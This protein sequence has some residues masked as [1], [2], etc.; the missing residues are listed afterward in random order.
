MNDLDLRTALHRD[1][2]LVGEPSPDLLEQLGQRRRRERRQRFGVGGAVLAVLVIAAGIP[3]GQSLAGGSDGT[4]VDPGPTVTTPAPTPTPVAPTTAP[5]PPVVETP[6]PTSG[7]PVAPVAP[8][9]PPVT[10]APPAADTVETIACPSL[11]ALQ[12]ALPAATA[13]T[14]STIQTA[15]QPVCSD[16]WAA[17]GYSDHTALSPEE[18]AQVGYAET[19]EGQAGLFRY[20]GGSWT[21]LDRGDHCGDAGIPA[22]VWQ[23]ACNVD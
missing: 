17:A 6:P 13:Q 14:W 19:S 23:R 21:L 5:A 9:A 15:E 10:A 20:T 18:A 11:D 4:A 22:A 1:A 8:V 12:A 3:L 16:G 2:D 7:T